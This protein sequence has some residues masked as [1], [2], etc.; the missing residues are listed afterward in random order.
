[1]IRYAWPFLV[2]MLAASACGEDPVITDPSP[3]TELPVAESFNEVLTVN[4]AKTHTFVTPRSGTIT[5]TLGILTLPVE[6]DPQP[7]YE[8]RLSL[9]LGTWNGTACQII[10]ADDLAAPGTQIVGF[11]SS[12]GTLCVRVSDVGQMVEPLRYL[13]RVTHP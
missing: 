11:A 3:G 9:A 13:L 6:G 8:V 1:M 7:G 2:V 5:A 12:Q 10:I 4:G